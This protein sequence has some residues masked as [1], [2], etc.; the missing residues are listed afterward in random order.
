VEGKEGKKKKKK[1]KGERGERGPTTPLPR[2]S[3]NGEK[4]RER[5]GGK[6]ENP[7]GR[8]STLRGTLSA[9]LSPKKGKRVK[10]RLWLG[11][12]FN[13]KRGGHSPGPRRVRREGGGGGGK[14][15]G[16]RNASRLQP[17]R[18]PICDCGPASPGGKKKEGSRVSSFSF[19]RHQLPTGKKKGKGKEETDRGGR[20][21]FDFYLFLK[22]YPSL[23]LPR[24]PCVCGPASEEEKKKKKGEKEK[25]R[26]EAVVVGSYNLY[27][28]SVR[29]RAHKPC[30]QQGG[31]GKRKKKKKE[32]DGNSIL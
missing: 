27:L 17:L 11:L 6:K 7:G 8:F 28:G 14:G 5:R 21:D 4:E 22:G 31:E 12:G 15:G 13:S 10:G 9:I 3:L 29:F 23:L 26:K 24:T 16:H 18:P 1:K 2:T 25:G 30:G 19:R 20:G 32:R